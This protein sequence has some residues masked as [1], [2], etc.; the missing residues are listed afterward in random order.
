MS[1]KRLRFEAGRIIAALALVCCLS[2]PPQADAYQLLGQASTE[3]TLT[4]GAVL[5]TINLQT[6]EGLINAYVVK[7]D[8]ADPYLKIDTIVGAN[9]TLDR[10]QAVS[11]MAA[12]AGAVAA[13]NGD[14][15]QMKESGRPIGLLFQGGRLLASPALRTDM[16][17]F[18]LTADKTPV[19]DIFGFTGQV[20]AEN[21][22]TFPLAGI[23]KPGYLVMSEESSDSESLT[24]YTP[25]WGSVSR[26]KLPD[27]SGVVEV[28]VRGGVVSQVLTDQPGVPLPSGGYILK[29]HGQAAKFLLDNLPVGS[30]VEVNSTVYPDGEKLFAA[31][32]G[33]ALLVENGQLPPYFSQ[34]IFG[35]CA[36]TAAGI[37][38]DGRTLYLVAVER[39]LDKNKSVLSRGMSQEELAAFLIA[40]GVWR[41]VNLDGGGSTTVAARHPGEFKPVLV[42]RPQGGRER[43]V[44]DAVGVFTTA[45]A[46]PLA[47]LIL[48]GPRTMLAG[49]SGLF[50]ASGY[51]AYFNPVLV[52]PGQL[53]WRSGAG[54]FQGNIFRPRQGGTVAVEAGAGGVK[55]TLEVRVIGSESLTQLNVTPA[56]ATLG[57][58]ET[59]EFKVEV[60]T[61]QGES[62]SLAPGDVTWNVN[63]TV[64]SVVYGQFTAAGSSATGAVLVSFQ[65]LTVS[66]PVSVRPAAKEVGLSP[67]KPASV[68]LDDGIKIQ[69]S[70][71]SVSQPAQVEIAT[72][73]AE[74]LPAGFD[75]LQAFSL[76]LTGS[77]EPELAVP[78]RLTWP[79]E[80]ARG[81][82][83]AAALAWDEEASRWQELSSVTL[84]SGQAKALLA[85]SWRPGKI[86]LV[87]DRRPAPSFSDTAGHWAAKQIAEL[88]AGGVVSGFPDGAFGPDRRLTRAQFAVLL[89]NAMQWSRP[90][91][92]PVFKDTVPRWAENAVAAA[93]ARGV[94]KGYP[95]GRFAPD[96]SITRSEMAVVIARALSLPAGDGLDGY[97]DAAVIPAYAGNSVGAVTAAGIMQ[98][99]DGKFR[100]RDGTSRAEAATVINRLIKWWLEH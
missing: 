95:D 88:A 41:A 44:P 39:A 50:A 53:A 61:D 22:K 70:P 28:V 78:W 90:A 20:K 36:R 83:R 97:R 49:T 18:G 32:G 30:P 25:G 79:R 71:G 56:K 68:D 16:F 29:G 43:Q 59:V 66:A 73:E 26:G 6:D 48:S 58:G 34:N 46:G 84:D 55:G 80:A 82:G 92:T 5:Q 93:A 67:D 62:F 60:K 17:G 1:K 21:G 35:S 45:P 74:G 86:A 4:R 14:F 31:V 77:G 15:F 27:L 65:G 7:A 8:L 12:R 94:I 100:P 89:Q 72:A 98:G 38:Q 47:G 2:L 87:I 9:G 33:Q 64:G 76:E 10:N 54:D 91:Q 3:Q 75:P 42:N 24:M 99:G 69:F 52:K 11:A 40:Q 85:K 13:V 51:D 63:G 37:S 96:A 23:N 81:D 19:I 57:F